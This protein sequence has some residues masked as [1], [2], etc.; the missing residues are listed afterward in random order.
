MSCFKEYI[1]LTSQTSWPI[2]EG[3]LA[4]SRIIP[5]FT[6]RLIRKPYEYE[7]LFRDGIN[8]V[9]VLDNYWVHC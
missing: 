8:E 7:S 3:V 4:T 5:R 6:F 2:G 1:P 9:I